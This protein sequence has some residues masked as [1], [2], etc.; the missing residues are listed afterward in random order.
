VQ[1]ERPPA[2][3]APGAATGSQV[4]PRRFVAAL[5]DAGVPVV[6][7]PAVLA[8]HR[9]DWTGQWSG[10]ALGMVRPRSTDEVALVL[11]LA[12]GA[13]VPIQVQGGNT[14]LV[15]GSVPGDPALLVLT[16]GLDRV[17]PVDVLER[18][19]LVG[20]GVT[21]AALAA[22]AAAAGLRFGVDL[23]A[24]DTATIGGMAATNAGGIGVTAYGMMR[25][26]VRGI[27]AVLADGARLSTVG[28]PRKDNTGYDLAGLLVGSE[29][30]LGVITEVEL[31]LHPVPRPS[32][33]AL[34]AVAD[35]ARA[36]AAARSV[37]AVAGLLAA[38]VVDAE[39][40]SRAA[41]ALGLP[42]PL[43]GQSP[44]LLLLEVPD[45]ATGEGLEPVADLVVAVAT[46]AGDRQRLWSYRERQTEVYAADAA[47]VQKLDVSVRLDRLDRAVAA[48]RAV[49]ERARG[50]D[51]GRSRVGLFGHALDG[52]LHV[53]LVGADA[54]LAAEVL[55]CVAE[56]GG[57]ISA[58]HGIGRLKAPYLHL[59]RSPGEIAWMRAL[60]ASVDPAGLVNAGV[61]LG[62]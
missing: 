12:R 30:T 27:T 11:D 61:L 42:D 16:T 19:V 9:V 32:T 45:G 31:A 3:P 41:R 25:A 36:V 18:T 43:R 8:G 58:E 52:N 5:G 28:R 10:P 56:L 26:Q 17:H 57:S 4:L 47:G 14:G 34:L 44:W 15:G 48:I 50:G 46:Q 6:T 39:G 1:R 20:A 13:G 37:Q 2:S 60:K 40:T 24:R 62:D 22:H 49:V 21:A 51:A 35:L 38:E 29:G 23:A 53:Q 55:A 59:A 54:T 7:D 33:V